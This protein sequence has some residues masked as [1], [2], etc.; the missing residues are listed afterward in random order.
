MLVLSF[1]QNVVITLLILPVAAAAL[2]HFWRIFGNVGLDRGD[3]VVSHCPLLLSTI[4][5]GS[6]S[7]P[8][9]RIFFFT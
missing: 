1:Y 4:G 6:M 3:G 8:T 2:D 9:S 5:R 7:A